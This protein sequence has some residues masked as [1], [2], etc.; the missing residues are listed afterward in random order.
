MKN[1]KR[2]LKL[3]AVVLL[4]VLASIGMS[5]AGPVPVS[6][7]KRKENDNG[8]KIELVEAKEEDEFQ[9]ELNQIG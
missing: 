8:I 6:P 1:F 2:I 7:N 3:S 4:M 5:L 9:S